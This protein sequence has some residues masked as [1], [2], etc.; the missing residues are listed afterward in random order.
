MNHHLLIGIPVDICM[1]TYSEKF[2]PRKPNADYKPKDYADKQYN[3]SSIRSQ[4][5]VDRECTITM[6]SIS[7]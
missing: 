6:V 7:E 4:V 1:L 5:P 3:E 2:K